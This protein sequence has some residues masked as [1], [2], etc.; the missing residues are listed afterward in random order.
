LVYRTGDYAYEHD[1][2]AQFLVPPAESLR[3]ALESYLLA[4]GL[5]GAV[6]EQGS[7]LEANTL[8]EVYVQQLYG[9]F[10]DGAEPAAVL[11]MQL[12]FYNATNG[13]PTQVLFKKDYVQRVAL[14]ARTAAAVIAGWNKALKQIM[15]QAIVDFKSGKQTN[16]GQAPAGVK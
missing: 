2:Y 8:L 14:T 4:S 11:E 6:A 16:K 9:D 1:P 15:T 5:F 3:P 12:T 13:T 10:R 7:L